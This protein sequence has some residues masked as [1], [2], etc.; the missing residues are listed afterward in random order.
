MQ[1]SNKYYYI[2]SEHKKYF[3]YQSINL[4]TCFGSSIHRQTNSMGRNMLPYLYIDN[5]TICCVPTEYNNIYLIF[6]LD[7]KKGWPQ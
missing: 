5:K 3:Y 2:Q 4:A 1:V 6:V 7:N